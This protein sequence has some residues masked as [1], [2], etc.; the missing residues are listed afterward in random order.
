MRLFIAIEFD[1]L[2]HYFQSLQSQITKGI[3][4]CTFPKSFHLTLKFLGDTSESQLDRIC[5]SLKGIKFRSFSTALTNI[6]FFPNQ[7]CIKVIWLGFDNDEEIIKL[8]KGV[9]N[10]LSQLFK[11]DNRFHPHITLARVK[12]IKDMQNFRQ[13]LAK[14]KTE[15][16]QVRIASFKLIKSTLTPDGPIYETIDLG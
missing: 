16:Q 5:L 7:N 11:P 14:I 3:A 1:E 8:Q 13:S 15:K 6:G 12:F 4:K 9:D 2:K 10:A